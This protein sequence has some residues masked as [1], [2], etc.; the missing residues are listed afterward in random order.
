MKKALII[1]SI[2]VVIIIQAVV[3]SLIA[4]AVAMSSRNAKDVRKE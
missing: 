2:P 3:L 4:F 1:I